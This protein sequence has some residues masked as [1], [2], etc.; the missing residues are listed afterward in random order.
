MP[1]YLV[2]RHPATIAFLQ[3]YSPYPIDAVV[4]HLDID[5]IKPS[6]RVIGTLPINKVIEVIEK[7][8]QYY[9]FA[10]EV[11]AEMRGKELTAEQLDNLHKRLIHCDIRVHQVYDFNHDK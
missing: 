11:T 10:L 1:T 6:D 4:T 3:A 2:S 9:H 8:A 7:G 5:H